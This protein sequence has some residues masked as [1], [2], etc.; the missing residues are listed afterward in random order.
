M[1]VAVHPWSQCSHR[2]VDSIRYNLLCFSFFPSIIH[3][4]FFV[5]FFSFF[6]L[7]VFVS[8]FFPCTIFPF[9]QSNGD[10]SERKY[11][12]CA[13]N[14]D[15][16]IRFGW[17]V[18]PTY[19]RLSHPRQVW[20]PGLVSCSRG[21]RER[22]THVRTWSWNRSIMEDTTRRTE[23]SSSLNRVERSEF[24]ET[25]SMTRINVSQYFDGDAE[26]QIRDQRTWQ[27]GT[28]NWLVIR[29]WFA[30]VPSVKCRWRYKVFQRTVKKT[31]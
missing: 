6:S 12:V 23:L 5:F 27:F 4:F 10:F 29:I 18:P 26:S 30:R 9:S 2:H 13:G 21:Q 24:W 11:F 20:I 19:Q 7:S 3:L 8:F 25:Y 17:F 14:F 16:T 28:G 22:K 15:F 31:V 1:R